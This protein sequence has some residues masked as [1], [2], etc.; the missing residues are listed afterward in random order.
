MYYSKKYLSPIGRLTI[1]YD[2]KHITGLWNEGQKYYG[3]DTLKNAE[4]KDES[5]V[6]EAA[7]RWL[8]GYF[9]GENPGLF[10]LSL[11]PEGSEFCQNVWELLLEIPYGK[12]VTYGFVAKKT[13]EK[14]NKKAMAGQAVGQAVGRNPISIIIPCHR[15]I[16]TNGSLTGYAGGLDKKI[17]LLEHEGVDTTKFFIPKAGT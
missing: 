2:D 14:M 5:P 8:E 10:G 4:E 9:A 3:G 1:S 16:G 17:K 12:T 15:V 6:L 11:K 13:A 7:V